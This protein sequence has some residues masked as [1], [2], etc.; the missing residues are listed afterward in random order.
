M[1]ST[2][3]QA[4]AEGLCLRY[5]EKI[6]PQRE[7]TYESAV[8]MLLRAISMAQNIP[9]AWGFID[10]PSGWHWLQSIELQIHLMM[11]RLVK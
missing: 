6:P 4:Q 1:S 7:I 11:V 2:F 5:P 8:N 9:F 10:K 3:L